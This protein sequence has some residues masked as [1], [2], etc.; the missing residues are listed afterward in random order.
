MSQL[1]RCFH[2]PHQ[3]A[4]LWETAGPALRELHP[5]GLGVEGDLA[6]IGGEIST[7]RMEG[8][9]HP[10]FRSSKQWSRGIELYGRQ[11]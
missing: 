9:H 7:P 2:A 6:E 1:H 11:M 8:R 3:W 5:S 10:D 4:L